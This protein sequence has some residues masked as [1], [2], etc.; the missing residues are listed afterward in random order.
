MVTVVH[1]VE[2]VLL[3]D[4]SEL[5]LALL[6]EVRPT[7]QFY[8]YYYYYSYTDTVDS[9]TSNRVGNSQL[10]RHLVQVGLLMLQ[11]LL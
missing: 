7:S 10:S 6:P 2:V 1:W 3:V 11:L 8:Y 4:W 9:Y 5:S